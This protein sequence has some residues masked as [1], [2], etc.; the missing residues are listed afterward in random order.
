MLGSSREHPHRPRRRR[1]GLNKGLARRGFEIWLSLCVEGERD[2]SADRG[3]V[4]SPWSRPCLSQGIRGGGLPH[5]TEA[6]GNV[7]LP[8]Q[9]GVRPHL[10]T[11][12]HR[13]APHA[14][15]CTYVRSMYV[16]SCRRSGIVA[17]GARGLQSR[18]ATLLPAAW[19]RDA[20][21]SCGHLFKYVHVRGWASRCQGIANQ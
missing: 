15:V 17:Q 1:G 8:L 11:I 10:L 4:R 21:S 20:F 7:L 12:G 2:I 3:G 19:S 13:T 14:P 16:L 6:E 18:R 5:E 9:P